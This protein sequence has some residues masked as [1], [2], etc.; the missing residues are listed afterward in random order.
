MFTANFLR[1]NQI[2]ILI[3]LDKKRVI[4]RKLQY[5]ILSYSIYDNNI[6]EYFLNSF[7][8]YTFT[9]AYEFKIQ[10]ALM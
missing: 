2:E 4:Q 6:Y 8:I 5:N 10:K 9:L 3:S 7:P 1:R